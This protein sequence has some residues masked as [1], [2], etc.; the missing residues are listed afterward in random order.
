MRDTGGISLLDHILKLYERV[1]ERR[2]R[3]VVEE[4]LND[5]QHGFRPNRSTVDLIFALRQLVEKSWE[6]NSPIYI[7][8]LDLEKAF[9]RVPRQKLWT[10]LADPY[11]N[12][13]KKLYHNVKA[14]Y[15]VC[16]S[17]VR[18]MY[19]EVQWFEV[20]CGVRQGSVLSPLLFI[21]FMDAVVRQLRDSSTS[22]V[23]AD[24]TA[25]VQFSEEELQSIAEDWNNALS[26]YGM[27]INSAKSEV[28][29]IMREP[30]ELNIMI[31]DIR[32]PQV[33]SV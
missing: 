18:S 2:L 12:V 29:C 5:C 32:V 10:V 20:K 28:I 15:K 33:D 30:I 13:P 3:L 21:I 14:M 6:F 27:R 26:A 4:R 11:Y 9:D 25:A 31:N 1:L 24:D 17:S 7:L 19:G 16:K 23:Y 8:A 22:Y